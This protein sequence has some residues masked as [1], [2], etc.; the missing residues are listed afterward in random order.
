[1]GP[2]RWPRGNLLPTGPWRAPGLFLSLRRTPSSRRDPTFAV[3]SPLQ[4]SASEVSLSEAPSLDTG[5]WSSA[6]LT[7]QMSQLGCLSLHPPTRGVDEALSG[8]RCSLL[9]SG[10]PSAPPSR[11]GSPA[12]SDQ[13]PP[14][15]SRPPLLGRDEGG[16]P[17]PGSG[18]PQH[19]ILE[20][21]IPT[22]RFSAAV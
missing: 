22:R 20:C 12:L 7:T 2:L 14:A 1:M 15:D 13:P 16:W 8:P 18:H 10:R 6:G 11:G 3:T 21:G 9:P 4:R 19:L 5:S 17:H